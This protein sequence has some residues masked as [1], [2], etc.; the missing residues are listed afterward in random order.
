VRIST[1]LALATLLGGG[2][3]GSEPADLSKTP[4]GR[5]CQRAYGS[6]VDS[7]KDVFTQSGQP[8]PEW[9]DRTAYIEK[10]AGLGFNEAQLKCLDPKL[11]GADPAGCKETLEPVKAKKEELSK[12]FLD[13]VKK[14][15]AEKPEEGKTEGEGAAEEE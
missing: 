5:L 11:A 3:G 15:A 2:C 14:D 12:W 6:T 8:M 7:L 1:V 13:Q 9:P 4:E 10:C